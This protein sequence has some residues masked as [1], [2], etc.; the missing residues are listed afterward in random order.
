M[1]KLKMKFYEKMDVYKKINM[2]KIISL[3][4]MLLFFEGYSQ[5]I[6]SLMS[7][8]TNEEALSNSEF[9]SRY[10]EYVKTDGVV[11]VENSLA[12][13]GLPFNNRIK[14][15]DSYD[16]EWLDTI[17][18][19]IKN[20]PSL[21]DSFLESNTHDIAA[22]ILLMHLYDID[23]LMSD[24]SPAISALYERVNDDTRIQKIISKGRFTSKTSIINYFWSPIKVK[25]VEIV[26]NESN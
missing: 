9:Y 19:L 24:I 14:L 16:S 23:I 7:D 21:L 6:N 8:F 2:R 13:R 22:F 12:D 18:V 11:Y 4:L 15:Q 5:D 10:E 26:K 25:A 17:S 1:K 20:N 3:I